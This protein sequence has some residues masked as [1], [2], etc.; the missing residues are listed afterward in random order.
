MIRYIEG[1]SDFTPVL[2]SEIQEFSVQ[3]SYTN[4]QG[5]I[6]KAVVALYRSLGGG[7]QIRQCNDIVPYALKNEMATRTNWGDL[8]EQTNHEPPKSKA[9]QLKDLYLPDW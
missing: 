7:W 3:L 8:L 5:N 2:Q 6:P 4:A 9:Q 1:Q